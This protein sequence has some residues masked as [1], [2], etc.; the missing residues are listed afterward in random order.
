MTKYKKN[1]SRAGKLFVIGCWIILAL[2][3]VGYFTSERNLKPTPTAAPTEA[4]APQQITQEN[5]IKPRDLTD[6]DRKIL[7]EC[8]RHLKTLE[9]MFLEF[10]NA[11]T[12]REYG[13]AH[14]DYK[15][16]QITVEKIQKILLKPHD[17]GYVVA[18]YSDVYA[19]AWWL[20]SAAMEAASAAVMETTTG[21][22]NPN[23][24]KHE[25]EYLKMIDETLEPYLEW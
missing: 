21:R 19:A 18:E 3:A 4:P 6:K 13:F 12:F 7:G 5:K 23:H 22:Q 16:W 15:E 14:P 10:R 25:R 9:N 24:N 20:H 8:A 2:V 17:E 1:N 11:E